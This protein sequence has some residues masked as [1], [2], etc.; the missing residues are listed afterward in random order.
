MLSFSDVSVRSLR[1]IK[2]EGSLN[3]GKWNTPGKKRPHPLKVS[4]LDNFDISAIRNK[5]NEYYCVKKQVPT[6]RSLHNELKA[7]IGFSGCRETLRKILHD[8]G[9]EFKNNQNERALLIERY[10]IAA[11]RHRYLRQ[12]N[13]RRSEGKPINIS[14][15]NICALKL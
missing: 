5:I 2:K 4:N 7:T 6:L 3:Q 13:K 9:F 15:R 8:N 11:W 14:R 12:V 10:D 1:R